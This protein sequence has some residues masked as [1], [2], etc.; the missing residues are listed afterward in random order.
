MEIWSGIIHSG[1]VKS[2]EAE[3]AR[4]LDIAAPLKEVKTSDRGDIPWF[5]AETGA[6]KRR[7]VNWKKSGIKKAGI[8]LDRIYIYLKERRR[9]VRKPD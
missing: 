6:Q 8:H 3:L 2:F 9:P 1:L 5:D 4:V 7:S